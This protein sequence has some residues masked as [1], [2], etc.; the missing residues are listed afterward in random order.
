MN[1]TTQ[2]PEKLIIQ[3]PEIDLGE[4]SL[5]GIFVGVDMLDHMKKSYKFIRK[6]MEMFRVLLY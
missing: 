5:Y 3:H 6:E 1:M 2:I 4:R